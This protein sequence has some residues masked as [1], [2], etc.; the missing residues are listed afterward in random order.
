MCPA[1]VMLDVHTSER[2][3]C[4]GIPAAHD[5]HIHKAS[6]GLQPPALAGNGISW[7]RPRG[8]GRAGTVGCCAQE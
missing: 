6:H 1:H 3:H 2:G 7:C 4:Q 5:C 8:P